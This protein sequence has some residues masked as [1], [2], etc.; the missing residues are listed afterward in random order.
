MII[1][2]NL[3]GVSLNEDD[4]N[5]KYKNNSQKIQKDI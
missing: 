2:E 4:Y 1:K 5:D 3:E